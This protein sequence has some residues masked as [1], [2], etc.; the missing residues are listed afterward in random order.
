MN[1][2]QAKDRRATR[3][4]FLRGAWRWLAVGG[5]AGI[6]V[7]AARRGPDC[8]RRGACARCGAYAHCDLPQKAVRS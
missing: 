5:L 1:G 4:E 2:G 8:D 7:R 6:G 3:R